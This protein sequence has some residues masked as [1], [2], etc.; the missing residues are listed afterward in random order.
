MRIN[1]AA[2]TASNDWKGGTKV[3]FRITADN[4]FMAR[5]NDNSGVNVEANPKVFR[6]VDCT[7]TQVVVDGLTVNRLTVPALWVYSTD[8]AIIGRQYARF[9]ASF[10]TPSGQKISD[11]ALLSSFVVPK[12]ILALGDPTTWYTISQFNHP[13]APIPLDKDTYSKTEILGLINDITSSITITKGPNPANQRLTFWTSASQIDAD[14]DLTWNSS[15]NRLG[16]TGQIGFNS[17]SDPGAPV[18]GEMWFADGVHKVRQSGA[19]RTLASL[20]SNFG[21]LQWN[22]AG[23]LADVSGSVVQADGRVSLQPPTTSGL[24]AGFTDLDLGFDRTLTF[25]GGADITA[26]DTITMYAPTLAASSARNFDRASTLYINNS[27]IPGTNVTIDQAYGL[28]M[29]NGARAQFTGHVR[30]GTVVNDVRV[31]GGNIKNELEVNGTLSIPPTS[32]PSIG[33]TQHN[34]SVGGGDLTGL[35]HINASANV[36]ITGF[37]PAANKS[38]GAIYFFHNKSAFIVTFKHQDSGSLIANR[39][40][41]IGGAD[42]ALQSNEIAFLT[43]DGSRWTVS[44]FNAAVA[45]LTG[46]LSQVKNAKLDYGAIGNG[47]ADDTTALQNAI[48]AGGYVFIPPGTYNITSPLTLPTQDENGS[49]I[50]EGAGMTRTVIRQT[51]TGNGFTGNNVRIDQF[52]FRDFRIET[53]NGSSVGDGFNFTGLSSVQTNGRFDRIAVWNFG[54]WG[55][56]TYNLQ[57]SQIV[58]CHFRNNKIGHIA[59]ADDNV[60][61]FTREPNGNFIGFNLL[62]NCPSNAANVAVIKLVNSNGT[63]IAFNTLQ[64]HWVGGGNDPCIWVDASRGVSIKNNH[65]EA[66]SSVSAAGILITN[67][68]GTTIENGTGSGLH[69][70]DIEGSNSSGVTIIGG[71]FI[72]DVPHFTLD[73]SC[74]EWR[75]I[76]GRYLTPTNMIKSDSS[77]DGIN[78][79]GVTYHAQTST[80]I[81]G[82]DKYSGAREISTIDLLNNGTFLIDTSLWTG[83]A[84][85]I[86]RVATGAPPND[87]P[88]ILCNTQGLGDGG[89]VGGTN[90][91][92]TYSVPNSAPAGVYTLVFQFYVEDL[93]SPFNGLRFLDLE[94]TGSGFSGSTVFRITSQDGRFTGLTGVWL[95]AKLTD[96]LTTGTS[97][98]IKVNVN[99]TQGAST[100]RV[101]FAN[102][103]LYRGKEVLRDGSAALT[104]QNNVFYGTQN[105]LQNVFVDVTG[106]STGSPRLFGMGHISGAG[107]S[108][109]ESARFTIGDNFNS[110]Q[111]HNSG[112]MTLQSFHGMRFYGHTFGQTTGAEAPVGFFTNNTADA[113]HRFI[114]SNGGFSTNV[115]DNPNVETQ[116]ASNS[117]SA[118]KPFR[119]VNSAGTERWCVME[120]GSIKI[121]TTQVLKSRITG[122]GTPTGTIARTTFNANPTLNVGA[123]YSQAELTAIRDHLIVVS[124]RLGAYVTDGITHG[125]IGA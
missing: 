58:F 99:P 28:F 41:C 32:S 23:V 108:G 21:T 40:F 38:S 39:F 98:T 104:N 35:I 56:Q 33:T 118:Y 11:I 103:H 46:T 123:A 77:P 96:T 5:E 74:R 89:Q 72:N 122:W 49:L 36:D 75:V 70:K 13:A 18:D 90:F 101:R 27:P 111:A 1:V 50:L 116:S 2:W 119:A 114:S 17:I 22:N 7:V 59:L 65:I 8:D 64:G 105:F 52:V 26:Q 115:S 42:I 24:T 30:F 3:R 69:T 113:H 16:V 66:G 4:S 29:D 97:R 76:G 95:Q 121:Q 68:F 84:T 45:S 44:R 88:Y 107:F 43:Y 31:R 91:T 102:F 53:N 79:S 120:D 15:A 20:N 93:G 9:T 80:V 14:S 10:V 71:C 67:S 87:G 57:S 47:V 61:E 125:Y 85:G 60:G 86:T 55:L 78:I 109:T 94:F 62:D 100:P 73:G 117:T 51:G 82:I 48:N 110:I 25:T 63:S 6:E 124:Q 12:D 37:A 54:G 81:M 83:A 106:S 34:W 112:V 92:Q 19:T